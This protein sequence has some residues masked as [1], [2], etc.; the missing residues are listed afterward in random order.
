MRPTSRPEQWDSDQDRSIRAKEKPTVDPGP[1]TRVS[2]VATP[3][4]MVSPVSGLFETFKSAG[5]MAAPED[6]DGER[7][8][9]FEVEIVS[10]R[11]GRSRARVA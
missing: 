10:E 11:A 9:P 7:G 5:A 3:D 1:P 6:R 2:I 8:E 4:S